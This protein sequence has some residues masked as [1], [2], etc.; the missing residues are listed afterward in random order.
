MHKPTDKE[1]WE[2][3]CMTRSQIETWVESDYRTH[4]IGIQKTIR[5]LMAIIDKDREVT[6]DMVNDALDAWHEEKGDQ[7]SQMEAALKAAL[8]HIF[9][10]ATP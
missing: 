8:A 4:F 5:H 3:G 7:V 10:E 1:L 9:E 2:A 6:A